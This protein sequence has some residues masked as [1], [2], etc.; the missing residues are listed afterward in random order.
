MRCVYA[1]ILIAPTLLWAQEKPN[2]SG[3]WKLDPLRSRSE[4]VK[5]P[6]EMVLKILHTEPNLKI[7]ILRDTDKTEV[8]ELKTD[9]NPVQKEETTAT[10]GWD[11]WKP[12]LL[13]LS[14]ERRTPTGLLSMIREIRM[15]DK[16]KVL[17]TILTAKEGSAG[18][19]KA[20]EFYVKE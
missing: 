1:L 15:G 13:V 12:E 17:T 16:G 8:L 4:A 20:Y 6:K 5:Q 2:Y 11:Q 10:A 7:E 3:T 9:G 19:K 14:I 18:E